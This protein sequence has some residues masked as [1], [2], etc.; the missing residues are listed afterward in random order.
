MQALKKFMYSI[1][2]LTVTLIALLCLF[3]FSIIPRPTTNNTHLLK[4]DNTIYSDSATQITQGHTSLAE[5]LRAG[6]NEVHGTIQRGDTLARSFEKHDVPSLVRA[7]FIQAFK[8][9][10]DFSKLQPGEQYSIIHDKRDNLIKSVYK[11]NAYTTYT[12]VPVENGFKVVRDEVQLQ[13]KTVAISGEVKSSLFAAFPEGLQSPRLV[14]AFADIFASKIDF[15]TETMPGDHISL[16]VEKYYRINEFI[17]YGNI[18]AARYKK[19]SGEVFEGYYYSPDNSRYTYYD[20]NGKELGSSFIRSPVP[21]GR[22]SSNF[23]YSRLHPI[24]GTRRPH[25]GVDLAAPSGSPVMAS[26]DGRIIAMGNSGGFGKLIV[27]AHGNDYKTY[28]GHLAA[29]NKSLHV[30][31]IVRQKQIIGYVG[32]TGLATGPHLDYRLQYRGVFKNPF[33]I[34]FQPRSTLQGEQLTN[35]TKSIN[36]LMISLSSKQNENLLGVKAIILADNQKLTLL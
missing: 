16:I 9:K 30:G 5:V 25:L 10:V 31:S 18:L 20:S 7:Q 4:Q 24:L 36:T 32:S 1:H 14:Y 22:I 28:Y 8:N 34:K 15:N 35:L 19:A 3:L 27:V 11:I 17:G 29:F 6:Y 33:A 21:I 13:V 12:A 2:C 26:A 23:T